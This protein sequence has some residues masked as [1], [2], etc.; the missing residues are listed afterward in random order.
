MKKRVNDIVIC[1]ERFGSK[2]EFEDAVKR[3]VM[4][5]LEN[6]YIM[7]IKYDEP[8]LGIVWIQYD[9]ADEAMGSY[10]P[11]WLLPGEYDSIIWDGET[12]SSEEYEECCEEDRPTHFADAELN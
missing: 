1:R 10:Y 12:D 6:D 8:G 5:L 4:V 11:T 3:V 9:D 7:T 2:E